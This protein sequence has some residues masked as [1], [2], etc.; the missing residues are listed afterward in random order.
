MYI[1][2]TCPRSLPLSLMLAPPPLPLP[3]PALLGPGPAA[4]ATAGWDGSRLFTLT[5]VR[6]RSGA[7]GEGNI[8]GNPLNYRRMILIPYTLNTLPHMHSAVLGVHTAAVVRF[9]AP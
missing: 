4:A 5:C 9:H 7:R 6:A 1:C 3:P 8:L 2:R